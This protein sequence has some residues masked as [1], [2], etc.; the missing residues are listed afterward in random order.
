M[1]SS[2]RNAFRPKHILLAWVAI[3]LFTA[4]CKRNET[5]VHPVQ[6]RI[7]VSGKPAARALVTFH[8]ENQTDEKTVI[9]PTAEVDADGNFRLTSFRSGDGAPEGEYRVSVVWYLANPKPKAVEDDDSNVRNNLPEVYARAATTPLRATVTRGANN[10][11]T[12]D[13]KTK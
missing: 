4:G 9:R 6:G 8:P 3:G 7:L 13:L 12:V 11:P 5:K 10:L 1:F 2:L